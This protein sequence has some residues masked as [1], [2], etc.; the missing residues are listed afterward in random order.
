MKKLL[1]ARHGNYDR[2]YRLN[3]YGK[4]Q[5]T[6]LAE[7]LQT[8]LDGDSLLILSSPAPRAS[9]SADVMAKMLKTGFEEVEE[10]WDDNRHRG[11]PKKSYEI[12]KA[13]GA[14]VDVVIAITHMEFTEYLPRYFIKDL[15]IDTLCTEIG[16]GKAW[17]IDFEK[18]KVELAPR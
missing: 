18:R 17:E 13:R 4:K 16:Q 12:I 7:F 5:M 3:E 11:D 10:L 1:I 6:E 14:D 15:G 8:G 2:D 9:D